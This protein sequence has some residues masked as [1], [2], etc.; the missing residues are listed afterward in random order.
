M[1]DL[2]CDRCGNICNKNELVAT[3]YSNGAALSS[4]SFEICQECN[5]ILKTEFLEYR[6]T[7]ETLEKAVGVGGKPKNDSISM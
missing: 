5:K 3:Y 2:L 1:R 4:P 6:Y 7:R